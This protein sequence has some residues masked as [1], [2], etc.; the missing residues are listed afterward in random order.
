[1]ATVHNIGNWHAS[2][3]DDYASPVVRGMRRHE[4]EPRDRTLNDDELRAV[5]KAAESSGTFGA[6][7]RLLL[8]TGQRRAKVET[9]K[10]AD[11]VGDVWV[12]ATAKREKGNAGA[13]RLPPAAL[14]IIKAQPRVSGNPYVFAATRGDGPLNAI[15]RL[16]IGFDR[17]CGVKGWVLHDLRRT[18]R[19]LMSRAKVRP[20]IAERVLGHVIGGVAGTYDQYEYFDE[21]ADVL[22]QLAAL[23]ETIV[24]P[25]P[26]N[27]VPLRPAVQS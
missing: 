2:R 1:L 25:P 15:S 12:I 6:L 19:S 16:K 8:L 21:K 26:A 14:A 24:N 17:D 22:V 27:V 9:M 18:S 11:V 7:V 3:S 5:W 4:Y 23:I 13:L 20:D 10:W